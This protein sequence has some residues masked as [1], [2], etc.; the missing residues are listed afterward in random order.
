MLTNNRSVEE[1]RTSSVRSKKSSFSNPKEDAQSKFTNQERVKQKLNFLFQC[2]QT[3]R[4]AEE[5]QLSPVKKEMSAL[6]SPKD[7]AQPKICRSKIN[8]LLLQCT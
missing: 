4:S 5:N 6:S 1:I 8:N 3:N 7:Y 2:T